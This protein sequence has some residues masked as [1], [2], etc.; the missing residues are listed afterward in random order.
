METVKGKTTLMKLGVHNFPFDEKRT[1]TALCVE[2]ALQSL[3]DQSD[4]AS[5]QLIF[6]ISDGRIERDSRPNLRRLMREMVER[7]ILLVMIVVEGEREGGTKKKKDSIIHMKEVTFEKGKPR[8]NQ[9]IEE[10]PF[11]Y[12]IILEDIQSF[13]EVLGDALRQWFE[14]ITQIQHAR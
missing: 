4:Q 3:E 6:L 1:R 14:M 9:F 11:P 10:Y 5:M 13:P 2:S 12:Y 8:V 7:K